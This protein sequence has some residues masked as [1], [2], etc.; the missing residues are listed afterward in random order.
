MSELCERHKK[1][2]APG[3][4]KGAG[5]IAANSGRRALVFEDDDVVRLLAAAIEREGASVP[6]RNV[7]A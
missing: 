1:S 5:L 2:R 4:E 3:G 7:T 6:L